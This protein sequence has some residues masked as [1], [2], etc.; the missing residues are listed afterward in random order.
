MSTIVSA[1]THTADLSP[2]KEPP[3]PFDLQASVG[4]CLR[5]I[6]KPQVYLIN[7]ARRPVCSTYKTKP[8]PVSKYGFINTYNNGRV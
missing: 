3:H 8:K 6:V 4:Q 7:L 5:A 1:E 2:N